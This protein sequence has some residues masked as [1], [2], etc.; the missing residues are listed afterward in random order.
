MNGTCEL[1]TERLLLRRY[2]EEDAE[3]LH[4][5]FG[6]DPTMYEYSGWNPYETKNM[7]EETVRRFMVSY[8]DEDFYGWAITYNEK[9]IGTIGAYDYDDDR[10]EIEVGM[11]IE[12]A[13]WISM[14][15][16]M[17]NYIFRTKKRTEVYAREAGTTN[18]HSLL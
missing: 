9:L 2:R 12:R 13:S 1:K 15:N 8:E 16:G 18:F 5:N 6:L 4:K 3:I 14:V 10:N 17:I 11:S 7:A